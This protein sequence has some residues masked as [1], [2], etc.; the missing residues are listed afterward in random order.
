MQPPKGLIFLGRPVGKLA[1]PVFTLRGAEGPNWEL[2]V[3][4]CLGLGL[5]VEAL[6]RLAHDVQ[7]QRAVGKVMWYTAPGYSMRRGLTMGAT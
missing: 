1:F 5:C 7:E 6:K 2:R 3:T 4:G